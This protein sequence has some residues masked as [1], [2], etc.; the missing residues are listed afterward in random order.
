MKLSEAYFDSLS[1]RF[2][3]RAFLHLEAAGKILA[4]DKLASA[5]N[6]AGTLCV[7]DVEGLP[8]VCI[9]ML[10]RDSRFAAHDERKARAKAGDR[11]R[12]TGKP[13]G[14]WSVDVASASGWQLSKLEPL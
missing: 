12:K 2:L 3:Q 11:A 1:Y 6:P 8:G 4:G 14:K 13:L 5:Q 7:G 9:E 10:V